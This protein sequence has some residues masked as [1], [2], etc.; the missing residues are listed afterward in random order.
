MSASWGALFDWDGVIID[1]ASAHEISW[2]R[3]ADELGKTL[4]ENHFLRGF[5]KRNEVI[6]PEILQWSQ[7]PAEIQIWSRRKEALYREV[8]AEEGVRILPGARNYLS[9][10]KQAGIPAV[11]G[12]STQR[13]NVELIFD[14]E[15][16]RDFF[17][18]VVSSE[19]V[20]YGKPDPEVFLKA[21]EL[22]NLS[23][24]KCVV[25]EDAPYGVEAA[26]AGGIKA[27]GVLTTHPESELPGAD[28]YV[29]RLDELPMDGTKPV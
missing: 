18:G 5:G 16:L 8:V 23:P 11:V 26:K 24:E 2:E 25:F 1:S 6:F 27:V 9:S 17:S 19:D 13:E 15:G 29:K 10:L 22:T 7:D 12:T 20:K 28:R 21:A 3:L 4:P 14:M